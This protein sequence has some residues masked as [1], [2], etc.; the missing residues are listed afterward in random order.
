MTNLT[1]EYDTDADG[2]V[3]ANVDNTRT[4]ADEL[5]INDSE[6]YVQDSQPSNTSEGDVWVDT[7][8]SS[9][10]VTPVE[11][12]EIFYVNAFDDDV[13]ITQN[14]TGGVDN[15]GNRHNTVEASSLDSSL[16]RKEVNYPA[17]PLNFDNRQK[18]VFGFYNDIRDTEDVRYLT[19]GDVQNGNMGY[20]WLSNSSGEDQLVVHDG[21]SESTTGFSSQMSTGSRNRLRFELDPGTSITA[22]ANGSEVA[23]A[24]SG[25]PTGEYGASLDHYWSM[26]IEDIADS[27]SNKSIQASE[28]RLYQYP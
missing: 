20:G 13:G 17:Y 19:V 15:G 28:Y 22:Y 27:S 18:S 5:S 6:V 12:F 11:D 9:S 8:S 10:S 2:D 4:D 1:G 16:L 7:G 23:S 24:T 14:G 25:L 3:E 26:Y 21:S